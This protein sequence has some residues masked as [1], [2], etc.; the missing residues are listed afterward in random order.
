MPQIAEVILITVELHVIDFSKF[1]SDLYSCQMT[2]ISYSFW[3][4][5]FTFEVEY[6]TNLKLKVLVKNQ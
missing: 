4:G 3:E 2:N 5:S 1:S 6:L